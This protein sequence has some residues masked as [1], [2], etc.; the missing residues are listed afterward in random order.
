MYE[1]RLSTDPINYSFICL[2][3]KKEGAERASDYRPI[4]LLNGIQKILSKVLAN[5]LELIMNDLISPSQSV[6]L[7]GRSISDA[8]VAVSEILGWGSKKAIEGVALKVD[9]EKAYDRISWAFL[10][11]ILN[12]WGFDTKWCRWIKLCVCSAKV[13]VL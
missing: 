11:Q 9:F 8:F 4:S 2:I 10:F 12:W 3:P 1:G 5:R 6:F 13:A 7:K